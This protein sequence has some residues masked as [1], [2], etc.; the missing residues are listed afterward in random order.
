MAH[1]VFEAPPDAGEPRLL[2]AF[3]HALAV[4]RMHLLKRSCRSQLLGRIAKNFLVRRAVVKS[5][6]RD[7][8]ERDEVCGVFADN[9]EEFVL[10]AVV[11][12]LVRDVDIRQGNPA[13]QVRPRLLKNP[14]RK[15]NKPYGH[16]PSPSLP[17]PEL[18]DFNV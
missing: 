13:G 14:R 16:F 15:E 10:A 12:S 9:T 3:D 4:F 7:F 1:A 5:F 17:T 8:H 2:Y 18:D 11:Q 6:A